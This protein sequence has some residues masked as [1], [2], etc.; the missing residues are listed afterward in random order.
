MGLGVLHTWCRAG[1]A[2]LQTQDAALSEKF[3]VPRSVKVS[4]IKPSGTVS[5]LAGATPG[6]HFPESR[7]YLR[8]LRLARTSNLV[9]VLRDAG[10]RVEVR[11]RFSHSFETSCTLTLWLGWLVASRVGCGMLRVSH[12]SVMTVCFVLEVRRR[13]AARTARWW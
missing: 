9:P 13:W 11:Q 1:Y 12:A 8:R 3:G 10:F 7:F 5:L 2:Q 4:C 6:M